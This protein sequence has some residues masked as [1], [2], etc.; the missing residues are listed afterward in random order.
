MPHLFAFVLFIAL[1]LLLLNSFNY[2]FA[3][4]EINYISIAEKYARGEFFV[5]PN[6]LWAPLLS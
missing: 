1:G 5:T 3:K 2:I 6:A 4:D